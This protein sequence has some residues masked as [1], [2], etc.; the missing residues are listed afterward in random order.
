MR[1]LRACI[2]ALSIIPALAGSARADY[3]PW[4]YNWSRDPHQ[5]QADAPGTG[6]ITLTDESLRTAVGES[7]IV[8]TNL[9][10]YS[11]A[12]NA[13]PDLFTARPYNLTLTITDLDSGLTGSMTFTGVIDGRLTAASANLRNTFTGLTTQTLTLGDHTYV[14]TMGQYTP[15]GPPGASNAGSMSGHTIISVNPVVATPEPSALALS[16]LGLMA[17]AARRFSRRLRVGRGAT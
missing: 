16:G 13:N 15:P 14:A 3:I 10:T 12:T 17:L 6:Y 8:A 2:A 7:D 9:R 1:H 11:T 4:M 5:I